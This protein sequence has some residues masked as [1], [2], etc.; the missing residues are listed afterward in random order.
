MIL[1]VASIN[2][3]G[4]RK[5]INCNELFLTVESTLTDAL[6]VIDQGKVKLAL[7]VSKQNQLIGTISDGDIRRAILANIG[8]ECTI[9]NVYCKNPLVANINDTKGH[10]VDLCIKNQIH[11][12]PILD[13]HDRVVRLEILDE[14]LSVKKYD[15]KV[16]LMVG[17]LG[18][19]LR[20]LTEDTPKPMLCVG[21]KPILQTIVEQILH[22]GFSNII[23]CVGYKSNI[24]RNFFGDGSKFGARIEYV[25]E[26]E[27]MG[28]A[29]A[30]SLL[31]KEQKPD[32][33]FILMNGDLLTNVRFDSLL[34]FHMSNNGKA[35]ISVKEYDFQTPYGVVSLQKGAVLSIEEKPIQKFFVSAGIY[36]LNP[37]LMD[38]INKNEYL[39]ITT[40][41]E[42]LITMNMAITA[43]PI[44]EYWLDIGRKEEYDRANDEYHEVFNA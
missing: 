24:I 2:I 8:L 36:V 31:S 21:S 7:V 39:D 14:L 25:I 1:R 23:M 19:R 35:T 6:K 33:P 3:L 27:R 22:C 18:K 17:G 12:I 10:I 30:L 26:N 43:F 15:N 34:D 11:Q 28:T 9:D 38:Q 37:S 40:L 32:M 44:M 5:M 41:F 13:N 16:I 29:G 4:I 42:K 20:P